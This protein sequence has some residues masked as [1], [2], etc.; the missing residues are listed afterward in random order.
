MT[1]AAASV[2]DSTPW[3]SLQH[4]YGSA[5]DVPP[6]LRAIASTRGRKLYDNMD[7]LCSRVLHQGTIY[8]ASPAVARAL[9]EM[10]AGAG[11]RE[12]LSFYGLL[13]GMAQAAREA[14][15]DGRAIPCCSG[16]EPGDGIAIRDAILGARG[17]FEPDLENADAELRAQAID[18]LTAFAEAADEVARSIRRQYEREP[19]SR[20]RHSALTGLERVRRRFDDWKS[21]LATALERETDTANRYFLRRAQVDELA[22]QAD[23]QVVAE[24]IASFVQV[25]ATGHNIFAGDERFFRAV[26]QLGVERERQTLL[27]AMS[28]SANAG[29]SRVLAERLL[30]LVFGDR[31]TGWEETSYSFERPPVEPQHHQDPVHGLFKAVF[32]MLGL[33]V[34]A[35]LCPPLFRRRMSKIAKANKGRREIVEYWG[36]KGGGPSVPERLTPEQREVLT[37]IANDTAL[38]NFRTNLWALFELPSTAQGLREFV[39]ARG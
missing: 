34:L 33:V 13:T 29:L 14:I 32:R 39:A 17:V 31:R 36:V 35:K 23:A 38:W 9:I 16:G 27:R 1:S 18:L 21:F 26:G 12:R 6:L 8:S 22:E 30:R 37:A 11:A 3:N 5:G 24:L 4:A 19:D 20:V 25:H 28:E 7:E 15:A 10:L 2:I